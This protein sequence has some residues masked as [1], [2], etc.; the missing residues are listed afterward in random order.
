[1]Y[2]IARS[3]WQAN[4]VYDF[5]KTNKINH[6][7]DVLINSGFWMVTRSGIVEL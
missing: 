7:Y 2:P 6:S 4:G 5:R 3:V 1:M